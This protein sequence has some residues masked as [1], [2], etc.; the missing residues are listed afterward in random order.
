VIPAEVLAAQETSPHETEL[1]PYEHL[2]PAERYLHLTRDQH[3]LAVLRS[4]HLGSL[5]GLRI[6]ELGCGE[7]ALLKTLIHYGAD[8]GKLGAVDIDRE[9]VG[10]ARASLPCV[11]LAVGDIAS[12]PYRDAA[13]DLAFAF[14][15]LTSVLDGR[16]RRR[17]AEEALRVLRPG[18]LLVVYDFWV[19]PVNRRV[20]PLRAAELRDLFAPRPVE[21]AKVTLAP[22]VVRAL[23][24]RGRLCRPLERLPF[25]RTHLMATVVKEG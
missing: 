10:R 21:V 5:A 3:L 24:G 15:V 4:H 19:N 22:P 23:G 9:R 1:A 13:F 12:L 7:G 11:R 14:T 16:V 17:G 25:L 8:I 20:R 2:D 6:L 18:G